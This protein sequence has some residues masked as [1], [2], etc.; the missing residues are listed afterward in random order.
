MEERLDKVE[1]KLAYTEETVLALDAIV[2]GQAQEISILLNRMEKLEKRL[3]ALA[4]GGEDGLPENER[5][6][7]Y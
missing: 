7:H 6:P 5:P 2:R 3:T 1:M 4:D